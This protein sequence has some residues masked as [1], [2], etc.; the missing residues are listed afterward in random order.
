MIRPDPRP[1][2]PVGVGLGLLLLGSLAGCSGSASPSDEDIKS[3]RIRAAIAR[4]FQDGRP[5]A[6]PVRRPD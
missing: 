2:R 3:E 5:P 6:T 1:R 4:K